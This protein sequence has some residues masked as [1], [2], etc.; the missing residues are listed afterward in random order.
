MKAPEPRIER[1]LRRWRWVVP[2]ATLA[3][4][5]ALLAGLWGCTLAWR[6]GHRWIALVSGLLAHGVMVV[7]V[8]DGAHR[9]ITRTRADRYLCSVAA[10]LLIM[11]FYG[12]AFHRYHLMHHRYVN[13]PHDP[14]YLPAKA[15][16]FAR[17]RLAYMLLDC[18][19]MLLSLVCRQTEVAAGVHAAPIGWRY[20]ATGL[21][22][23]A[24]VIAL[25]WPPWTFVA[26]TVVSLYVL[27]S[28]RDWCEHW[29]AGDDRVANA[30]WFP[31][32]FG[33]GN[34]DAHHRWPRYS[35][36]T[37]MV[38]LWLRPKH[39]H[40]LRA[41]VEM[42]TSARFRHYTQL[43]FTPAGYSAA[44][45]AAARQGSARASSSRRSAQVSR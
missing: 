17:G 11:P 6:A 34:H 19:P 14:L 32:G 25:A 10:G 15:R 44:S 27:S 31:F 38:G 26:A 30:Y 8:H 41:A 5:A 21:A 36:L 16:L 9:A 42:A 40:P 43:G 28:I 24:L 45:A 23:S 18:V 4:T 3:T 13:G 39:T 29:G 1:A 7:A 22:A 35:W 33:I 12:E 37:M 20:V 2:A